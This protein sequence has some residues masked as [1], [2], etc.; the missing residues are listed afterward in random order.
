MSV[1]FPSKVNFN[2][3]LYKI[4]WEDGLDSTH[5]KKLRFKK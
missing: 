5:L 2:G 3:G 1:L 4:P